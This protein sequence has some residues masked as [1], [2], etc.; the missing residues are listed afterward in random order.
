[1]RILDRYVIRQVLMPF[2]L[3]LLV[4]TFLFIIPELMKYAEEYISKGAPTLV[5][6]RLVIALIPMA[7]GLTIPMSLLLGLLVTFGRLSAD[8][9]FVALQ[10]CGVSPLRLM[11]PVGVL[12]ILGCLATGYVMLVAVPNANQTFREITFNVIATQAEG[13]V[14]PRVFYDEFPN[15]VLYVRE[16][17]QTGGWNG[18]FMADNRS[19]EGSTIYLARRGRILIDRQKQT[20]AM[21][22][23]DGMRHTADPSGKYEVFRFVEP[24]VLRLDPEHMFPKGGLPKGDR[25]MSIAE[26][27]ARAAELQAQGTFPH[28]QLFEIHKK[29]S[30]PVA[31]LVF[32]LIG[33]ALGATNRRDGK[34]ANFVIGVVIIF[35]YYIL[36]FLGQSL[37]KGRQIPPWFGAWLPDIVLGIVGLL[38]FK[39]RNR[40]ADRPLRIPIPE[41]LNRLVRPR[42]LRRGAVSWPSIL[43]R[44]VAMT[45]A[46]M[47]GLSAAALA[48]VFYIAEFTE[49][50]E[51]VFKGA[52]TW[53]MLGMYLADKTPQY[54][55][56]V[57]PL[58]V[59][60]AALVTIAMLT[61]NSELVVMKACGISLYRVAVPMV[62]GAILA[63]GAMMALEQTVLGAA[64]RKAEQIKHVMR[65]GSSETFDVLNRR[66]VMGTDGTIYH[67]NYFDPRTSQFAN[68][69]IYKFDGDLTRVTERAFATKASY[70]SGATWH[71]EQGWS[72]TFDANGETTAGGF[73]TFAVNRRTLEPA[74]YFT[75]QSPDPEFMS[76]T[77][78]RAYTDRLEASGLDV[79]KQQVALWRKVSFPFV[80]IIM[81]LLAVP[82]AVTIGRS[83]AMAGIAAAIAIAIVYWTTISVFAAMGAGG[84]IAPLLAAWAPNLLFGAGAA[85]LLL[86]VRT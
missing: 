69:W 39:W 84:L 28:N 16:V 78:L 82:F 18:V 42:S 26:L 2:A 15:I 11:R 3:G 43:D 5:I 80:T 45:Y 13:E 4:F 76:Y 7:L 53:A 50:S 19:G 74:S 41:A 60:L 9:E 71:A 51:K 14:K 46:R 44:Y 54:L 8:R 55:Y 49:L 85:Y 61:K 33:L 35:A 10:A 27:R 25:E 37:T 75:T 73:T 24:F 12:S 70:E 20:V 58:S 86:T 68:L 17:P 48:S 81:T 59:L 36:L 6:V 65:G 79:V 30:I 23:E 67:Y 40:V 38:L 83:G 72:R 63:G 57:I 64:N 22:L 29:F 21:V 52:A 47:L 62:I 66:W 34:L 31:C 32:G 77:Q 1:M 56:Y